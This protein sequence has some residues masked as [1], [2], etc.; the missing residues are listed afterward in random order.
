MKVFKSVSAVAAMATSAL[1]AH[2]AWAALQWNVRTNIT[3]DVDENVSIAITGDAVVLQRGYSVNITTNPPPAGSDASFGNGPY[4]AAYLLEG[5]NLKISANGWYLYGN[6]HQFRQTGGDFSAKRLY[7]R[8]SPMRADLVFGGSGSADLGYN[9]Y[10]NLMGDATFAV[11]D[12]VSLG[13]SVNE[14]KYIGLGTTNHYVFAYNGGVAEFNFGD[15]ASDMF[16]AFNGG[17]RAF[18]GTS[19]PYRMF[20]SEPKIRIYENGGG[21]FITRNDQELDGFDQRAPSGNVVKSITLTP[22]AI[23]NNG[24]GWDFPPQVEITDSTGANAAAIVDYD[25]ETRTVTNIT[26]LCGGEK[27]TAPTAQFRMYDCGTGAAKNLLASPLTCVVGTATAGQFTFSTTNENTKIDIKTVRNDCSSVVVDMD[28]DGLVDHGKTSR[29]GVD[30]DHINTVVIWKGSSYEKNTSFPNC[31]NMIVKSGC[32]AIISGY[33]FNKSGKAFP[34]CH[35]IEL[36]GGHLSGGSFVATNVVVGG[37]TWLTGHNLTRNCTSVSSPYWIDFRICAIDATT[38]SWA[39]KVVPNKPGRMVIDVDSE[40]GPAV[41]KYGTVRFGTSATEQ[42]KICLRNYE[43]L[44]RSKRRRVLLDLSE[45]RNFNGSGNDAVS[46]SPA[47]YGVP[48]P[49]LPDDLVGYGR[50]KWDDTKKKLYWQPSG[51]MYLIFR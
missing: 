9:D 12:S 5:G 28:R 11:Q 20:G 2:N 47:V 40:Y 39:S 24:A 46:S 48:E 23:D 43:S 3:E 42:S 41:L 25:Y 26:V 10:L 44:K 22:E 21:I 37:E 29:V 7:Y 32:I 33:G 1:C 19:E 51:G 49:V 34:I 27:Y 18:W 35:N 14:Y 4:N 50:L 15:A 36:Y 31:I 30:A 6:Y 17:T 16:T 38:G 45:T 8:S 13:I